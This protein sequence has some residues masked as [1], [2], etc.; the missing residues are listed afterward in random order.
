MLDYAKK[1]GYPPYTP[2]NVHQAGF[3][4]VVAVMGSTLSDEQARLI[5]ESTDKLALMFDGDDAGLN[6]AREFWKKVRRDVFMREI[7]L[8]EREQPDALAHHRI[9]HLLK[10]MKP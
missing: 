4:N 8:K 3:P 1:G 9:E 7:E 10:G 6:C 2:M 5:V